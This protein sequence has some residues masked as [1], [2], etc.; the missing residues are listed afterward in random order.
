FYVGNKLYLPKKLVQYRKYSEL[1]AFFKMVNNK[2]A[3]YGF[4]AEHQ[5]AVV[6]PILGRRGENIYYIEKRGNHYIILDHKQEHVFGKRKFDKWVQDV[7]LKRKNSYMIQ[8]YIES[9]TKQDEP[10]DIRAHM[11]KNGEGKWQITKIY[12]R[13]G[14]RK[15][16]LSN[17]S[18]GG[19]SDDLDTFLIE[20][21]GDKGKN[22]ASEMR[23]V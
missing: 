15:S 23:E 10:F 20:E 4:L 8:K 2:D 21:F 1:L 3:V 13:I 16:I 12:P 7:L 18:R 19:R 9:R 22:Y 11:Q 6:K 5:K 14:S 17:I